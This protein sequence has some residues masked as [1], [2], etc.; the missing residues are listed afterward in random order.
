M[1]G[2]RNQRAYKMLSIMMVFT[3]MLSIVTCGQIPA[4]AAEEIMGDSGAMTGVSGEI[5]AFGELAPETVMQKVALGTGVTELNL[6]DMLVATVCQMVDEEKP[7]QEKE[8][9]VVGSVYTSETTG[10]ADNSNIL[11]LDMP[12]PLTWISSPKYDGN[13]VGIYTFTAHIEGFTV[14]T[15]P[16][17]INVTVE[18]A[19]LK[20]TITDFDE[21]ADEIRWQNTRKPI[22]PE[23]VRGTAESETVPI[24]VTW[25]TEQDYDE[26]APERGLYVFDA[27]VGEGYTLAEDL[28]TPRIT[29]YIPEAVSRFAPMR[30]GGGGTTASPLE[31]TTA[32]QLAEIAELVNAGRLESFLFNDANATVFLKLMNDLDLSAYGQGWN[33]GKGWKPIGT[34][35]NPF[36]GQFDGGEHTIAGLYINNDSSSDYE[37]YG[38]CG[39]FGKINGGSVKDLLLSGVSVHG[40]AMVG[41]IA[42]QITDAKIQHCGVDGSLHGVAVGGANVGGVVGYATS[43]YAGS[44]TVENCYSTGRVS[45]GPYSSHIGGIVGRI[46]APTTSIQNCY[47]SSSV[48]GGSNAH[49]VGGIVGSF[50]Y[51]G[52][53]YNCAALNPSVT[54]TS[55]NVGRVVGRI[56][57][58]SSFGSN[59]AFVGMMTMVNGTPKSITS[60]ASGLDGAD[61]T[62]TDIKTEGTIGGRF[63]TTNGWIIE[64]GKLPGFGAAIDIPDYI[65]DGSDPNF[66]GVGTEEAPFLI[67]TAAQLA[68]LATQV[69][70][71][72]A[73]YS[74]EG[75]HYKLTANL[76][77]SGY[78]SGEGWTPIGTSMAVAF[79]GIFEGNGKVITGLN[80]NRS[81]A[82]QGL[83][84]SIYKGTVQNLRLEDVNITGKDYVGGVVGQINDNSSIENCY[85]TGKVEGAMNVGGVAGTAFGDV[86]VKFSHASGEV[87]GTTYVG[88][89]VGRVTRGPSLENCY[90]TSMV[91]GTGD[92]VGGV[93]GNLGDALSGSSLKNC[94]AT[95]SVSGISNVGGVVGDI[96]GA[97][98]IVKNCYATGAVSGTG[99]SVGGIA[100]QTSS[101]GGNVTS[102]AALNPSV[103]GYFNVGRVL[104][105][106]HGDPGVLSDNM[107]FSEMTVLMGGNVKNPLDEGTG[108]VDGASKTAAQI[109]GDIGDYISSLF[110]EENGWTYQTG[111]LPILTGLDGQDGTLPYHISGRF[112]SGDGSVGNQYEISTAAQL[113]K[114]AELV[115][116]PV[117]NAQYGG[118][119]VYYKL[120]DDLDLSD[121][122]ASNTGFNGG[123]GWVPIGRETNKFQG[124]FDGNHK[125]ITGL[126]INDADLQYAGLLGNIEGGSV[127]K[128][129]LTGVNIVGF[130]SV[131]GIA[132]G[133]KNAVI[134]VCTVSGSIHGTASGDAYVG[135]V[136][137]LIYA[138]GKVENC[139]S[140]GSVSGGSSSANIGGIAGYLASDTSSVQ[141]CYS[142]VEAKGGFRVGG[143]AGA[144]CSHD[145]VIKN[146]AALNPAISEGATNGRVVGRDKVPYPG[147]LAGNRAFS[148]MI[149][150]GSYKTADGTDGADM[151]TEQIFTASF[152]T[153]DSNWD[154]TA[155][156]ANSA[157]NFQDGYLPLLKGFGPGQSGDGGLYLTERDI[158]NADV[159]VGGPYTYTGSAIEPSLIVTFDGVTLVKDKDYTL[160][161][162]SIDDTVSVTSAGT[163]AGT[164]TLTLTGIGNFKGENTGVTYIIEPK[165][166]TADMLTITGTSFTYNGL[167]QTPAVTV[168]DGSTSLVLNTDYENVS[169]SNNVN[170]GTA[171]VSVTGKG[172]YTGTANKDFTIGEAELTI[173]GGTVAAKDYDGTIDATV[174]TVTFGGLQN[175]ETLVLGT[176]YTVTGAQFNGADA[177]SGKTVTGMVALGSTTKANNYTL[178]NGSLSISGQAIEKAIAPMGIDQTFEIV[179]GH[180]KNYDFDLT[181]LLPDVT[182]TLGTLS[183][184]PTID[185]NTDGVLGTTLDYTSGNTLTL[186]VQA[187][188]AVGKTASITVTISSTNYSNFDATIT[189]KT[190]A[191]TPVDISGVTMT[192]G[193]YNGSPYAYTGTPEF[194]ISIGGIPVNI[195]NFDI[196]YTSADGG[197]YSAATA[198]TNA[199]EY[200]LTISVPGSNMAYTGSQSYSFTIEK[201]PVTIKADDK[202]MTRGS[203]LPTFT[204]TLNGQ[205]AGETAFTG[206]PAISSPTADTNAAGSY[207]IV[208]DLS[209]ISYTDNYKAATPGFVNGTLT[210]NP[211]SGGSSGGSGGTNT[212]A[213][214]PKAETPKTESNVAGNIVT[215]TVTAAVDRSGH[216]V[217][218]ISQTQLNDAIGKAQEE[219]DKPGEGGA[220]QVEINVEAPADTTTA[221][222]SIPGEAISQ[223]AEAGIGALTISTPVASITFGTNALST[224]AEEAT[225][226]VIITASQVDTSSLSPE[227]QQRVG[228]RPV[229]DFS[230]TSGDRS[231]SQFGGEVSVSVPYTPKEGEDINAI[232]IY[233]INESGELEVVNNCIYDP[234][235]GRISFS[236]THFSQYVVGYNKVNFKDVAESA[237]H[238]KAISFIAAREIT[239]GTGNGNFSPEAKLT[240]GQFIVMLMKTYGLVPDRNTGENFADAGNT[241]YTNYLATAKRLQ[242]T[243]GVGNN[244]FRPEQEITRQEMFTL[245]YNG[246]KAIGKLPQGNSGKSLSAFS[247]AGD[248]APWAK[249]AMTLLVK[250]ETINGT[251]GKLSPTST[252]TRAEMAQ[253]LYSLLTQ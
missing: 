29:V 221:T 239:T 133:I 205:L 250:T 66:R 173:N 217:A 134:K 17:S 148:G 108:K 13:I 92:S 164:V 241:Y 83:F 160:V 163:N 15:A 224:L 137:G 5:I 64:N 121:Y 41:G 77:L 87:R 219:A 170:A 40:Y 206:T 6:P 84:G 22:L 97:G 88:G 183:Y 158:A 156:W 113:A 235:T 131:G 141:N 20:G 47:S 57:G 16:P 234:A 197:G 99:N 165:T 252:T 98:S 177:G 50:S 63:T 54:G 209:G 243:A 187:V 127:Q 151:T 60:D 142:T 145:S 236:T 105:K 179:K 184:A 150:G 229:F 223:A 120:T 159:N 248:I 190:V 212:P 14:S 213:E 26:N 146:C 227:A 104:G 153:T 52:P 21:L 103:S 225:G 240:R 75:V 169:Y 125:T 186:P 8:A 244:M 194:R 39:L 152:W 94:Y 51:G 242:I 174:T 228:D 207:P 11:T 86:S 42:G 124:H 140:T 193:V 118:E 31:I 28:E 214:T 154:S 155:A 115:N 172:N 100:G 232:V 89:V 168:R 226:D 91:S 19:A 10:L 74:A 35:A 189:V 30:M 65:T 116:D 188:D 136:V 49:N 27:V 245:L 70:A 36:K 185:I 61:I 210:I 198:P 161:I 67:D 129:R 143:I 3:F 200:R 220:A 111:K 249:D 80:I 56:D 7:G 45:G 62:A 101:I 138:N 112:F 34:V 222:I 126:Y 46:T 114:L 231:I 171:S 132:G 166:L 93:A 117:T 81:D 68:E 79:T 157:W 195:T 37:V 203:T 233:Y 128:L 178:A 176:D 25:Q 48:S 32:A 38:G 1:W 246:L 199:G 73:T 218:A 230:V 139:Y 167:V 12:V 182:G 135:G 119:N 122:G 58:S 180:A 96:E 202:T 59:V 69:N 85:V 162:T 130:S 53:V 4:Y 71:A 149:G 123:K 196:S 237:W 201:R 78:Q 144:T 82:N 9:S 247:D 204:Y 211:S 107:A 216:A 23:T 181:T 55:S 175:S 44:A 95:G 24:S 251:G 110:T 238:S 2:K 72:N 253:V 18:E 215:T 192:G 76:D 106:N 102:C 147:K 33:G 90:V 109:S 43:S 191:K 208:V